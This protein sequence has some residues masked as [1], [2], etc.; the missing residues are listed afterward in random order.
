MTRPSCQCRFWKERTLANVPLI[1]AIMSPSAIPPDFEHL[2]TDEQQLI[3]LLQDHLEAGRYHEAQDA[4]E[5]LWRGAV[6]AHKRLWQGVSNALTAVCAR[7]LGN[8]RGAQEIAARTHEML[9]PYPR[10]VVGLD[11]DLL[12]A[13]MDRFVA[14]GRGLK[15]EGDRK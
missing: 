8:L 5:D 15:D 12:L 2:D 9:T 7:E 1:V 10:R 13:T 14:T 3:R 4:A 6:D 11:L